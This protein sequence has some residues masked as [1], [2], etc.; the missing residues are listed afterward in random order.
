MAPAPAKGERDSWGG[1][2]EHSDACENSAVTGTPGP[3][4]PMAPSCQKPPSPWC[5]L[6]HPCG[7]VSTRHIHTIPARSRSSL[8]RQHPLLLPQLSSSPRA[9]SHLLVPPGPAPFPT[10]LTFKAEVS[11]KFQE[12]FCSRDEPQLSDLQQG[13]AH[14]FLIKWRVGL[15][16]QHSSHS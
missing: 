13:I 4:A 14:T 12:D 3:P 6:V 8:S 1:C 5:P 15:P 7:W 10:S 16:L 9:A 11:T 2:W